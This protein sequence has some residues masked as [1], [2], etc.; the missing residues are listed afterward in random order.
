MDDGPVIDTH[1]RIWRHK[2]V[3]W[4]QPPV[5]EKLFG[6][7]ALLRRDFPIEEW[8]HD[9]QRKVFHDNAISFYRI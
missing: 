8:M 2:D 6:D 9:V 7:Y 5:T 4:L 1:Q 3:G